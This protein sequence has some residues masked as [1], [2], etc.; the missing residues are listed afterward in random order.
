MNSEARSDYYI[1][2]TRL[3][4]F[5][6]LRW[7]CIAA[8]TRLPVYTGVNCYMQVEVL[9]RQLSQTARL[10]KSQQHGRYSSSSQ[11]KH[12]GDRLQPG[13]SP[14]N[15]DE[16]RGRLEDALKQLRVER[17]RSERQHTAALERSASLLADKDVLLADKDAELSQVC[18]AE[19]VSCALGPGCY[20]AKRGHSIQGRRHGV[21]RGGNVHPN[22]SGHVHPTFARGRS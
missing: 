2:F 13:N 20:S 15:S 6:L 10:L 7:R 1:L 22:W 8:F 17:E 9:H 16:T 11:D 12:P 19:I 21:H 18:T 3:I 4:L 14:P 5:L